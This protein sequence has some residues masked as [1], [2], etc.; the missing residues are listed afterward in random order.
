MSRAAEFNNLDLV[1]KSQSDPAA[2]SE[3]LTQ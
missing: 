3:I 1:L 2:L